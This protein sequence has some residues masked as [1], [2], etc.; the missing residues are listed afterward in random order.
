MFRVNRA[1]F[2]IPPGMIR[3]LNDKSPM[4]GRSFSRDKQAMGRLGFGP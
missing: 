4:V 2:V 3:Q 1:R